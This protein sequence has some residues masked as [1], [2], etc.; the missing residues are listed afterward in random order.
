MYECKNLSAKNQTHNNQKNTLINTNALR[1]AVE[2]PEQKRG[3]FLV[4]KKRPT[5][6]LFLT[7]KTPLF[8]RSCNGK[9][10][11]APTK[12]KLIA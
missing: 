8:V 3:R 4:E 12:T 1:I 11:R 7:K 6:A 9:P 2:T 5:E 10:A